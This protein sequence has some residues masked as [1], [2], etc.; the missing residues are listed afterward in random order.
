MIEEVGRTYGYSRLPRRQPVLAPSPAGSPPASGSAGR[1]ARCSAASGPREAWTPSFVADADHARIGPRR[2]RPWR[3][4]TPWRPRSR[5]CAAPCCPGCCGP[6]PTTPT[7]ARATPPLRGG[8]GLLPPRRGTAGRSS[9]AAPGGRRAAVLP[10]E[11]ELLSVVLAAGDDDARSAVAAWR[12][13]AERSRLDGVRLGAAGPPSR[14]PV[15]GLHP[16]RSARL[17]ADGAT[18][19]GAVVGAVGEVDPAVLGAFGLPGRRVGWLEVDLGLLLDPA[20]GPPARARPGRS[21]ASPRPTRPRP[22]GG[23]RGAG[24]PGGR[25]A[26]QAGG[27][28]ARVGDP[29]RRL[30]GPAVD[31]GRR[32]LAF[33][34]RF[35]AADRTLT[36]DE[37]GELRRACIEAAGSAVGAVLALRPAI[38]PSVA[39][40]IRGLN[41]EDAGHLVGARAGAGGRTRTDPA[42]TRARPG[43][44]S[45]QTGEPPP[46]RGLL[47]GG[48]RGQPRRH[49]A[50]GAGGP[51]PAGQ[52]ATGWFG[53]LVEAADTRTGT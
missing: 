2:A 33:R 7:G 4:P 8:H 53:R 22:G 28:A 27:D 36:D 40:F 26:A 50:L 42:S 10:G 44:P 12:V 9:G 13:L 47:D 11:R 19:P 30:P 15:P 6:W 23:R 39:R 46:G 17:V 48:V 18:A 52:A 5:S 41:N 1:C 43:R 29:V 16:T 34:L 45:A 20:V 32:S 51:A 31:E 49:A 3:W 14:R 38:G 37:V 21:A 24:R 35:C 25:R